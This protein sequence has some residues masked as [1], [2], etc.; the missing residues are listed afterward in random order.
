MSDTVLTRRRLATLTVAALGVVYGDIGTSPLYALRE[1]FHGRH[2]VPLTPGNVLGVLS[3]IIWALIL[4]ISLKYLVFVLRAHNKGEGG[5]LALL[6]LAFPERK[7]KGKRS[8][9]A[10]LVVLLGVFGSTLLYGDGIITP[11]VSILGAVEGLEVAT[12]NLK[13]YI[14]PITIVILVSLFAAQSAGTGKVGRLFGVVTM[15]WFLTIAILGVRGILLDPSVLTAVNPIHAVRYFAVN[16]WSG[17]VVLASVVLV[18][19]GGEALYA[20]MGHFGARPIRMAWFSVVLPALLLNYLGQGALL[21]HNPEAKTS[22]FYQLCPPGHSSRWWSSP[23]RPRS[24]L[25]RR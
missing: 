3:M 13:P 1:C 6:S 9:G 14:V 20:D 24:L 12:A 5:I 4:V 25:R 17:F 8:T 11:A 21:L 15:L 16:G 18:V 22:P 19:T 10:Q 7:G 2:S 23:P